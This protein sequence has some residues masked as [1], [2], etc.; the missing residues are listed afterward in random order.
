MAKAGGDKSEGESERAAQRCDL[1]D[2][3]RAAPDLPD[4]L[5]ESKTGMR[6]GE[7]KR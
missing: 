3:M 4:T 6:D 2:E 1:G 5:L 7:S